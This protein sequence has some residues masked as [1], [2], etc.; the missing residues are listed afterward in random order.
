MIHPFA[1]LTPGVSLSRTK[2]W[3][4]LLLVFC[5]SY[6][7]MEGTKI[8]WD[9]LG[10]RTREEN[11]QTKF[12]RKRQVMMSLK[13]TQ[14]YFIHIQLHCRWTCNTFR[15]YDASVRQKSVDFSGSYFKCG[16]R[17]LAS[18]C[19]C[20]VLIDVHFTLRQGNTL[21]VRIIRTRDLQDVNVPIYL[22]YIFFFT[23]GKKEPNVDCATI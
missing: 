19:K 21:I 7:T 1:N 5:H 3:S 23:C 6:N 16:G 9:F 11:T 13:K 22:L 2:G 4:S 20:V 17:F 12:I 10:G 18:M 15:T 8:S 14:T